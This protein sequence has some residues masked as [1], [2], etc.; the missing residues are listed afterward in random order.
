MNLV[1]LRVLAESFGI[2]YLP[3]K[4]LKGPAR[5]AWW[6]VFPYS[7]YW[8]T[9][10]GNTWIAETIEKYGCQ[11]GL[12][13]WDLGAHYGIFSVA[14]ARGV[15]PTGSVVAFEPDPVSSRRLR[16]HRC[17]N[18]LDNLTCIEAAGSD[19]DG[20]ARLYQYG[21]FGGT[22]SHLP[23]PNE[24]VTAVP[25]QEICLIH[26]DEWFKGADYSP[27]DFIKIDVEGHGNAALEG[28]SS[29]LEEHRP[30]I[31]MAFHGHD[32]NKIGF[33]MLRKLGYAAEDQEGQRVEELEEQKSCDLLMIPRDVH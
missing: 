4:V 1:S 31:L 5:G 9:D 32:E 24:N 29:V 19:H 22:T 18:Q 8:R 20:V 16:W 30:V 6:S 27:P 14:M 7:A 17:L 33:P 10:G 11:P 26:L 28:M 15:G 12:H 2:G 21:E 25:Y 3:V 13:C 23:F